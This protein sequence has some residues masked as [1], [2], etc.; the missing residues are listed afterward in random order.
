MMSIKIFLVGVI[1]YSCI[2]SQSNS[3]KDV[4]LD[5]LFSDLICDQRAKYLKK[6]FGVFSKTKLMTSKEELSM[7]VSSVDRY[8]TDDDKLKMLNEID[9]ATFEGIELRDYT[10]KCKNCKLVNYPLESEI[11]ILMYSSPIFSNNYRNAVLHEA[12][13]KNLKVIDGWFLFVKKENGFWKIVGMKPDSQT[14]KEIEK[15]EGD[16]E[17]K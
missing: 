2:G 9:G 4:E 11:G 16:L 1:F 17:G 13:I 10:R 5:K 15:K 6:N 7:F 12:T 8:L 3:E 14:E